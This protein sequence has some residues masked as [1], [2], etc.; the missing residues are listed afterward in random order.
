MK[1]QILCLFLT[2]C[3]LFLAACQSST[4]EVS[5]TSAEETKAE[6]SETVSEVSEQEISND[7]VASDT[8]FETVDIPDEVKEKFSET[9]IRNMFENYKLFLQGYKDGFPPEEPVVPKNFDEKH[10]NFFHHCNAT[11]YN[12]IGE[13]LEA[14]YKEMFDCTIFTGTAAVCEYFD[15]SREWYENRQLIY[16]YANYADTVLTHSD[17]WKVSSVMPQCLY[18]TIFSEEYWNHPDYLLP[19]Y[20]APEYDS[21][22][23]SKPE[24]D[25]HTSW[26]YYIDYQLIEY[27]GIPEFEAW[28]ESV[29][30][31][32]QNIIDFVEHFNIT[33][34][35]FENVYKDHV[36]YTD[37]GEEYY[38]PTL[39]YNPEYLFGTQEMQDLYFTIHPLD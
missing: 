23:T 4:P 20:V 26:Y 39:P 18:D 7:D 3:M 24:G 5:N 36:M 21:Y 8:S 17:Y 30:D 9:A 2:L 14:K 11:V 1:K 31:E 25:N 33:R 13:E 16:L 27:V 37:K 6:A 35:I 34:E 19:G 22:Y 32:G 12:Y 29:P 38:N 15:I 28:L 10:Y